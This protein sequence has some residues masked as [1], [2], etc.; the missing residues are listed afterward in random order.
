MKMSVSVEDPAVLASLYRWLAQDP[1]LGG[2]VAARLRP[3]RL[4]EASMG[5]VEVIDLIV[6]NAIALGSL[7]ISYA[8]WRRALGREPTVR[9]EHEGQALTVTACTPEE[10]RQTLETLLGQPP[11]E[12][13]SKNDEQ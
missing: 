2:Q 12:D 4:P 7:A 9:F 6:S 1:R 11:V 10:V 5:G 3:R 13:D 8:T